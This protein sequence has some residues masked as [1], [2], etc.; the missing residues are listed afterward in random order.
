MLHEMLH[1][2]TGE[3]LAV[4]HQSGVHF[5]M[6]TRR[7]APLPPELREKATALVLA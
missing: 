6:E 3:R 4:L 7:S 5:D 1:A 2:R